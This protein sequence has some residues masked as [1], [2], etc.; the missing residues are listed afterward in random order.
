MET[1][2]PPVLAEIALVAGP[3]AALD[4]ARARGGVKVY[5]PEPDSL[6]PE[7]WLVQA[8]GL[9]AARKICEHFQGSK[10]DLPL[11]P[12]GSRAETAEAIKRGIEAGMSQR[13]IARATGITSRT[14]RNH[15]SRRKG[16]GYGSNPSQHSLFNLTK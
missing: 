3:R 13:Q 2:L 15:N 11:G 14:V 4:L 6:T 16:R 5:F 10:L 1:G 7:H 8:C 12:S 9:E